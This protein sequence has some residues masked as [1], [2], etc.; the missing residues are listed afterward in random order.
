MTQNDGYFQKKMKDYA[1]ARGLKKQSEMPVKE[2][3]V[4]KELDRI[5]DKAF[6]GAWNALQVYNS[7]YTSQGRVLKM[8]NY[9]LQK[10]RLEGASEAQKEILRLQNMS[11]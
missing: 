6:E 10:G 1:K 4:H 5:H 2:F 9:E 8:R 11:K 3:L 7:R